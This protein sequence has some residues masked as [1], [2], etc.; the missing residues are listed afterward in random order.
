MHR[1]LLKISFDGTPFHGWQVQ[2]NNPSV[3]QELNKTLSSIFQEEINVVG[4]GRTDTGVHAKNFFLHFDCTKKT[5]D[6]TLLHKLNT[7][8]PSQ[9]AVHKLWEV[10]SGFNARFDALSRTYEYHIHLHKDPFKA[11]LSYKLAGSVPNLEKMN[12]A[13]KLLLGEK[14]FS[15]F[16]KSKTQTKTNNCEITFA[17]WV[18]IENGLVFKITANRFLRNMVRA[19]VGTLLQVGNGK[20]KVEDIIK[21][22]ESKNRSNAGS[23]VPACGLYLT[24]VKYPNSVF[25]GK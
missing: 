7:M 6:Y 15:C 13:A 20:V 4:C 1:Y 11:N 3:Q 9:I 25:N 19:I 18:E 12:Q 10:N 22:I 21:I 14:D 2:P 17:E 16:S 24:E 5:D 8:L 23:S